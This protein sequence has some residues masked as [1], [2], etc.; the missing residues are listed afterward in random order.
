[1]KNYH[2]AIDYYRHALLSWEK[3]YKNDKSFGSRCYFGLARAQYKNKAYSQCLKSLECSLKLSSN[4]K[5]FP[6]KEMR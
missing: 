2:K 3:N 1:M 6:L 4:L 5:D